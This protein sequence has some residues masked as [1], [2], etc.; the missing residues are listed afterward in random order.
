MPQEKLHTVS[1]CWD[2]LS[3]TISSRQPISGIADLS[4]K[5]GHLLISIKN[6]AF[7]KTL[8]RGF[9][10]F[11][12]EH[13]RDGYITVVDA[14]YLHNVEAVT[15]EGE[16]RKRKADAVMRLAAERTRQVEKILQGY[17][18]APLSLLPW[19][20]LVADVPGWIGEEVDAAY[21]RNGVFRAA[22][23]EQCRKMLPGFDEA[24]EPLAFE[25]FLLEE[26]P[27]LLYA[28]YLLEGGVADFYPGPIGEV[29]WDIDFG[30]L[31]DELPRVTELAQA[32]EGFVYV[33]FHAAG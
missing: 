13:M 12:T 7:D 23:A 1:A 33:E 8:I 27:P 3:L 25:R 32:H 21:A 29:F 4:D 6:R 19:R 2:G 31:T 10:R 24:A 15:P 18:D 14:P 11:V 30:R 28:Y 26:I 22:I 17:A 9:C 20:D 16:E 5:T